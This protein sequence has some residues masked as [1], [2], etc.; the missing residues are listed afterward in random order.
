MSNDFTWGVAT[1]S[2]QIEGAVAEDGR[3]PSIWDTFS[4]IKGNIKNDDNGDVACDHYHRYAQD[5]DLIKG[6]GVDA[7][8]L[9]LSWSRLLP[10]GTGAVNT[11]GVDFY[12][13]LFDGL[14]EKNI[15]PWVTLYHWD[16]PQCLQDK[17][18]W[19]NRDIISWFEEYSSVVART[20]GDR[21]KNFIVLNEPS[22]VCYL[23]HYLG[24]F[25]PGIKSMDALCRSS[26]HQNVAQGTGVRVLRELVPQ[27]H[28]GSSYTYF[29]FYPK[30]ASRQEDVAAA[31]MLDAVWTRNYI[32][33]LI[34]G[35][36]PELTK[37]WF[38]PLIQ[39]GDMDII[40]TPV[41]Y[42]GV[43]HYS[44][45]YAAHTDDNELQ[46]TM[47]DGP[48]GTPRTDIGW[49]IDSGD[50]VKSL[51]D[52]KTRYKDPL[53]YVTE[54]GTCDNTR[55]DQSGR[56]HDRLR[57][58][59]LQDYIGSTLA[60]ADNGDFRLGGYFQWSLMDNFEWAHG[61]GM[62][63]GLVDID[64]DTQKR[65]PKESYSWYRDFI[66]TRRKQSKAA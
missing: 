16:L 62:R 47:A 33:P 5:I 46:A 11:K 53:I 61:Y 57:Q 17:G 1:A 63:F 7:Y 25:A 24:I 3:T 60:A 23:G 52:I 43:N 26:H 22:I 34:H 15:T 28:I 49:V 6:L 38:A 10:E 39:N 40:S 54:N 44:P 58:T 20:F 42:I 35:A 9:S 56:V 50:L 64:Y 8:R 36:Y 51:K 31:S 45:N 55:P 13:R 27:A 59:Y 12:N 18:G 66:A 37:D 29:T 19:Q 14:L 2:Y 32:D 21:V 41:D 65:T 48:E 4:H 30:D